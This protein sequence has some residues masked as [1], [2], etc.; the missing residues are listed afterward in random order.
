[1][2]EYVCS[3]CQ[4]RVTYTVRLP[5]RY[6]FCSQRCQMVDLGKWLL[7]EYSIDRGLTPDDLEDPEVARRVLDRLPPE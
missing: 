1:M 7:E 3:T 6:P 5:K 4:K 2:R